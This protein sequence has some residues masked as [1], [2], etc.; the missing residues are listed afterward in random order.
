MDP[1]SLA[2]EGQGISMNDLLDKGPNSL[3]K[4]L[5]CLTHWSTYINI[6]VGSPKKL[7]EDLNNQ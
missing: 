4:L 5:Y 3:M 1:L 7:Q 6:L 2:N